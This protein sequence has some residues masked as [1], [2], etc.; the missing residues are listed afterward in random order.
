MAGELPANPRVPAAVAMATL[1]VTLVCRYVVGYEPMFFADALDYSGPADTA[2]FW[3]MAISFLNIGWGVGGS[4][5][6]K[7]QINGATF[8]F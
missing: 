4:W 7:E 8:G 2:I 6:T 5:Q 3:E 1:T